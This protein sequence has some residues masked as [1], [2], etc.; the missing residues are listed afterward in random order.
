MSDQ[1]QDPTQPPPP[2]SQPEPQPEP[3]QPHGDP[4]TDAPAESAFP[5]SSLQPPAPTWS[6]G[7]PSPAPTE[8]TQHEPAAA[9][10]GGDSTPEYTP[11][12]P[13][14]APAYVPPMPESPP[15]YAAP[16]PPAP[17]HGGFAAGDPLGGGSAYP[18]G[19]TS[20]PPPGAGG[21]PGL[22]AGRPAPG[23][24][25]LAGWWRRAGALIIDGLI[26]LTVASIIMIPLGVG[27]FATSTGEDT[28]DGGFVALVLGFVVALLVIAVVAMAY[29]PVMMAKTNGKTLGRMAVGTRVIRANG[30]AMT[31]G[32]A[33]LREVV[34]KTLLVGVV[35]SFTFGLA[36]LLDYL[37]PLWD[38]ENRALH[39]F[40]T[41]TRT[42]LD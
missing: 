39:D 3:P 18:E 1:S 15:P 14:E 33:A 38:D 2:P 23:T 28:S 11:P 4:L 16:S 32:F 41:D 26:I 30:Q 29:A 21:T 40:V 31:L 17:V 34:V 9:P 36:Q 22:P 42:I 37:W 19:Y 24:Y 25:R 35:S 8:W 7:D 20:P 27:L 12:P 10:Y 6:Q 13:P 5:E